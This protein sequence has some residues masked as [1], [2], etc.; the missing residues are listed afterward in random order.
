[1]LKK[2]VLAVLGLIAILL[3]L[4]IGLLWKR[5]FTLELG[6]WELQKALERGFPVEKTSLLVLKVE[7]REP[8]VTLEERSDRLRFDAKVRVGFLETEAGLQGTVGVSCR[9]RYDP[10]AGAFFADDPKVERLSIDGH[11]KSLLEKTTGAITWVLK[12]VLDRTPV[13]SLPAG[14]VRPAFARLLLKDVRVR[15]GKLCLTLGIDP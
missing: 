1:M 13:Y 10:A 9:I 11:P 15:N 2:V 12:G 3:L 8:I 5:T 7:L 4:A 14:D 6:Q